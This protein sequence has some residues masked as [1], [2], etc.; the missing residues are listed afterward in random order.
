MPDAADTPD[1]SKLDELEERIRRQ[2]E[3]LE[4]EEEGGTERRFEESGTIGRSEDDQ[5]IAPPG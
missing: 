5:T 4:G 3:R 1:R 2:K